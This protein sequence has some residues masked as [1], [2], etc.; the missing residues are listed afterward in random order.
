MRIAVIGLGYVGTVTG[1]CLAEE[2]HDVVGVDVNTIKVEQICAGDSPITERGVP[3]LVATNVAR[4]RLSATTETHRAVLD[5]EVIIVCVGTPS[6]ANG[7]VHLEDVLNVTGEIGRALGESDRWQL[8]L[9]TST[10]PPGTVE[11][12]LLPCLETESGRSAGLDFGIAFAPEFLREGNAVADFTA[13]VST[14]IGARDE[15]SAKVAIDLLGANSGQ[16]TSTSI[17][18]AESVK[19]AANAWH[20]LKVAFSNEVG[21]FCAT[22]DIDSQEVMRIFKQDTRLNISPTYLT[23]GFAFGGSCLPKDV[24]TLTYRARSQGAV[25]PVLD[26]VLA[27]NRVH[28]DTALNRVE[29][30]G[31]RRVAL[32]GLAFKAGTDDLRES[33]SLELAERLIGKGHEVRIHDEYVNLKR[34]IGVNRSYVLQRLPHIA[35]L[36]QDDLAA[37]IRDAELVVVS[38]RNPAYSTVLEMIGPGQS[39][40]DLT[41]VAR[42]ESPNGAYA[43]LLW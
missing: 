28:V 26:A 27:S 18:V 30:Y 17:A 8:V 36:L 32:L 39:V 22:L 37:V 13:P 31:A 25:L 4:G 35:E 3:E 6:G 15:R 16:V 1:A 20:G 42:P 7:D 34:L 23:P 10:V 40:L 2:G 33:P 11:G 9:V 12:K 29:Q 38:Q 43:G 41:G 21:R 5:S 24:R 14:V 19:F